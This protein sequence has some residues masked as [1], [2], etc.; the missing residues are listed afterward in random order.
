MADGCDILPESCRK[1]TAKKRHNHQDSKVPFEGYLDFTIPSSSRQTH[2]LC[3]YRLHL[4]GYVYSD[5]N[6]EIV[7]RVQTLCLAFVYL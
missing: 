6:K 7:Y 4:L 3:F 2:L 1:K 5:L